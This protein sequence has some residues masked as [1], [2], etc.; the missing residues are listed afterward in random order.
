MEE[1]RLIQELPR[2]NLC[3]LLIFFPEFG[4]KI[5]H[6]VFDLREKL[7]STW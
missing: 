1:E 2:I 4:N 7:S 5:C 6:G 3:I